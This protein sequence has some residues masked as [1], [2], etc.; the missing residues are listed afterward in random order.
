AKIDR[1]GIRPEDLDGR[2]RLG[3]GGECIGE[4]GHAGV[5]HAPRATERLLRFHDHRKLGQIE[6]ADMDQRAG[7]ALG[8]D[9][10]RMAERVAHFPQLD[11]CERRRKRQFRRQRAWRRHGLHSYFLLIIIIIEAK[12]FRGPPLSLRLHRS[13]WRVARRQERMM[14]DGPRKILVCSCEDS[15]P[16]DVEGLRRSCRGAEVT[17]GRH[18]CRSELARVQKMLAGT[19]PVTIACT[20]EAPLFA[21]VAAE[22]AGD[23]DG[24]AIGF[25]NIRENAG[26]S[27]DA[28]AAGPKIAALLAA[29]AEPTPEIPYVN[30]T[31]DGAT[32]IYGS[33]ERAIEAADLLKDHL[34]VT[35][36]VKPP[37]DLLPRS[38]TD[39]ALFKGT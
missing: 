18:L 33:D 25:V 4:R 27:K 31:S 35:V 38:V 5:E 34:A 2:F 29:A 36:I 6:A 32:V 24:P 23:K 3:T 28:R 13:R 37:G 19:A 20:Q 8:G 10:P 7:A 26:W 9:G 17:A 21:E 30:F 15:M 16:L 39:F 11:G 22:I 14:A 12:R 1:D